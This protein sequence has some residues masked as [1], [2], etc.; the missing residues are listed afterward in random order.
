MHLNLQM[1]KAQLPVSAAQMIKRIVLSLLV[2]KSVSFK[3]LGSILE[4]VG[5]AKLGLVH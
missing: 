2:V 5:R 1:Y 4:R 3:Y